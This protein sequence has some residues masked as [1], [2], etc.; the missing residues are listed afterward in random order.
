MWWLKVWVDEERRLLG[1]DVMIQLG[2]TVESL[3]LEV[4]GTVGVE[5]VVMRRRS[6]RQRLMVD[7]G[8]GGE[9]FH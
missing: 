9:R 3:R 6:R 5:E 2:S 1:H 7:G 4:S 8:G